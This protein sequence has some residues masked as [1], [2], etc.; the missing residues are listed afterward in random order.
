[1]IDPEQERWLRGRAGAGGRQDDHGDRRPS[2]L[3]R[4]PRY[5]P[6]RRR[7]RAAE[8]PAARPRRD[9]RHGGRHARS[10]VLRR[11]ARPGFTACPSLRQRRRRRVPELRHRVELAGRG[12]VRRLGALSGPRRPW[13]TRSKPS[14]RGGSGRPGGGRRDSMRGRS[15]PSGCRRCSTTT[16]RRSSRASSWSRWNRRRIGFGS[17][18]RRSRPPH[19]GGSV[20]SEREWNQSSRPAGTCRVG[21]R[22]WTIDAFS[23]ATRSSCP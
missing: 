18:L 14:R 19:L 5:E 10:R 11:A 20:G 21:V 8:G 13:R 15:Q 6:G 22:C 4:R 12:P 16:W 3:C 1:M 23:Q 7:V 9:D 2:F 17:S